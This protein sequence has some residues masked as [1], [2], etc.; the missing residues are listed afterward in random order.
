M[1]LTHMACL[2]EDEASGKQLEHS[3]ALSDFA[4]ILVGTH[5]RD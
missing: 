3:C 5:G 4:R 1:A 2:R